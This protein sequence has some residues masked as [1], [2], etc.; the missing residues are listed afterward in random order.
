LQENKRNHVSCID[1]I[2]KGRHNFLEV[3]GKGYNY[4][5]ISFLKS[6]E[7]SLLGNGDEKDGNNILSS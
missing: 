2:Y 1:S 3:R 4:I 6:E 5:T 7:K